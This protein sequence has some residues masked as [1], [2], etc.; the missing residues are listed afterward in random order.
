[1]SFKQ[2]WSFVIKKGK[3]CSLLHGFDAVPLKQ[4][5][6]CPVTLVGT[7]I[8]FKKV[9]AC[10]LFKQTFDKSYFF[11]F[12]RENGNKQNIIY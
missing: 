11:F 6:G 10:V 8:I 1:M 2:L 3:N 7:K 12:F 5:G 9:Y 4:T